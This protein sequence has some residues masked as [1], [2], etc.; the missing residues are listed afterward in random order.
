MAEK[1]CNVFISHIHEDDEDLKSFKD[2]LAKNGCTVRDSSITSETPNSAKDSDY[3]K[4][5]ILAPGI[6]W[7]GTFVVLISPGTRDSPWVDWEIEYAKKEGKRIIGVWAEGAA[8][9][10]VPKALDDYAD[11]VVGWQADR[12]IDAIFGD[13]NNWETPDGQQRPEREIPHHL[14]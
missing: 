12:I 10:D 11:A 6:T 2:L 5:E 7:A 8:D 4:Q 9:C 14:C 13:I 3:I 1:V